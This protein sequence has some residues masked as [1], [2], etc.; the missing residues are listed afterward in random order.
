[1]SANRSTNSHPGTQSA[2]TIPVAGASPG[3]PALA[4]DTKSENRNNARNIGIP[5]IL[6]ISLFKF[7]G[8][9]DVFH[10]LRDVERSVVSRR[11][12]VKEIAQLI[13][14]FPGKVMECLMHKRGRE[15]VLPHRY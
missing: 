6:H 3:G 1:M 5:F 11:L 7:R 8:A 14:S 4:N 13:V 15:D 10:L 9:A 2:P 12:H